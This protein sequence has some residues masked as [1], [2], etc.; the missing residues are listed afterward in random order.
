MTTAR[1]PCFPERIGCITGDQTVS[2]SFIIPDPSSF[3]PSCI[4][5]RRFQ[6]PLLQ[7]TR[8]ALDQGSG[9]ESQ[10]A[11]VEAKHVPSLSADALLVKPN[12]QRSTRGCFHTEEMTVR[13]KK[14]MLLDPQMS[15]AVLQLFRGLASAG[16]ILAA[17]ADALSAN[18][19]VQ[20]SSL[21][22]N[23]IQTPSIPISW[24]LHAQ[25]SSGGHACN[26]DVHTS[27]ARLC[28]HQFCPH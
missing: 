20:S 15:A 18:S 21:N 10:S 26:A 19:T 7:L 22:C 16:A 11:I 4:I 3:H 13:R 12:L 1:L 5:T 24:R 17:L 8:H 14:T 6:D 2:K 23:R 27:S 9:H 28:A 25:G